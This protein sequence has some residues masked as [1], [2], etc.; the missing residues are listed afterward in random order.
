MGTTLGTIIVAGLTYQV[1]SVELKGGGFAITACRHGEAPSID[2]APITIFGQ[3]GQGICQGGHID[4]GTTG[5]WDHT[6][7]NVTIKMDRVD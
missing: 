5:R 1:T 6:E 7:I 4:I 2:S 3:D